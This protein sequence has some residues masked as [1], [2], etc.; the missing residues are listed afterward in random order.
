MGHYEVLKVEVKLLKSPAMP[1]ARKKSYEIFHLVRTCSR[2]EE[3][4]SGN[5][6]DYS[7]LAAQRLKEKG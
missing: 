4:M 2:Q 6:R 7:H 5:L 1:R 3:E